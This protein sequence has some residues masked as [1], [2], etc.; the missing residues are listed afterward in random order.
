MQDE[1]TDRDLSLTDSQVDAVM[2]SSAAHRDEVEA[3]YQ[4]AFPEAE[5]TRRQWEERNRERFAAVAASPSDPE[6]AAMR[7]KL[8]AAKVRLRHPRS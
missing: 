4:Q 7:V 2:A 5:E 6:Q 3:E 1:R 8:A